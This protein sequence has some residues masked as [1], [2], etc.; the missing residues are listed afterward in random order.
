[1]KFYGAK[2]VRAA[3][4]I[5]AID[6]VP[7]LPTPT[8]SQEGQIVYLENVGVFVYHEGVWMSA[9]KPI[10]ELFVH[11][12]QTWNMDDKGKQ[13]FIMAVLYC[14]SHSHDLTD[15]IPF[16]NAEGETILL[17]SVQVMDMYR[18]YVQHKLG[19]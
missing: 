19:T 6:V 4:G 10:P 14:L 18:A 15:P 8:V 1:M 5:T 13:Q 2:D 17:T 9:V 3:Q 12:G 11:D 7:E 16:E